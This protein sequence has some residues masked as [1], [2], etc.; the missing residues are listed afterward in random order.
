[1]IRCPG[2]RGLYGG[3]EDWPISFDM[4]GCVVA[5]GIKNVLTYARGMKERDEVECIETTITTM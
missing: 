2:Y 1:M 4:M 3:V 5:P